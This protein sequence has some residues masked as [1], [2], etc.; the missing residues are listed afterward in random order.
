M[1]RKKDETKELMPKWKW[2]GLRAKDIADEIARRVGDGRFTDGTSKLIDDLKSTI[3][4]V[5][6]ETNKFDQVDDGQ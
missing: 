1:P 3:E 5:K 4:D 2:L 6:G